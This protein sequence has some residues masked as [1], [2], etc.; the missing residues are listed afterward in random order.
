MGKLVWCPKCSKGHWSDDPAA[1]D[2][3]LCKR[4]LKLVSSNFYAVAKAILASSI[5]GIGESHVDKKEGEAL[6]LG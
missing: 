1:P 3:A 4:H 2:E 5:T 6:L